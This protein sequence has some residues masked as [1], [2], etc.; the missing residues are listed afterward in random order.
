MASLVLYSYYK[1]ESPSEWIHIIIT[2]K[3][4]EKAIEAME[5]QSFSD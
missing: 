2:E 1:Q 3:G 4:T 5:D